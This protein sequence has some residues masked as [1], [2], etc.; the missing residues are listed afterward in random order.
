MNVVVGKS[1]LLGGKK[2]LWQGTLLYSLYFVRD[3]IIHNVKFAFV[4]EPLTARLEWNTTKLA[5]HFI[6]NLYM[7]PTNQRWHSINPV[8]WPDYTR[9]SNRS[10]GHCHCT[11]NR[12]TWHTKIH[13]F[14][15]LTFMYSHHKTWPAKYSRA[16]GRIAVATDG[17]RGLP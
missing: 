8:T 13:S 14:Y 11:C 15:N 4:V 2:G 1:T 17:C 7:W 3:C 9:M 10:L 5:W 12:P 6:L 16:T